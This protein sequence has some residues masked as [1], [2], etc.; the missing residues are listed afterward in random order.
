[1]LGT[2]TPDGGW[3]LSPWPYITVFTGAMLAQLPW[4]GAIVMGPIWGLA[5]WGVVRVAHKIG[6]RKGGR[7]RKKMPE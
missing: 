2:R 3:V 7:P 4:L 6:A 1:M 5:F